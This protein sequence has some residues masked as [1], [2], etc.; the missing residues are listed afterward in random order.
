MKKLTH[1]IV[2]TVLVPIMTLGCARLSVEQAA[3]TPSSSAHE[4]S[5]FPE[6]PAATPSPWVSFK[7]ERQ[8]GAVCVDR[9]Q[10]QGSSPAPL[11]RTCSRSSQI[12]ADYAD[13]PK[14]LSE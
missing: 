5:S 13:A 1:C 12:S 6:A 9:T 7:L 2:A 4:A 14:D 10:S 3:A 11:L 8:M